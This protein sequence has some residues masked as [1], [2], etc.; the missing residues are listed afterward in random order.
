[1]AV[2]VRNGAGTGMYAGTDVGG[3]MPGAWHGGAGHRAQMVSN[4]IAARTTSAIQWPDR[5]VIATARRVRHE[6]QTGGTAGMREVQARR[7]SASAPGRQ[8]AICENLYDL[9]LAAVRWNRSSEGRELAPCLLHGSR[10]PE[11][12]GFHNNAAARDGFRDSCI[13][14]A[15]TTSVI[16]AIT[17]RASLRQAC[18]YLSLNF[19]TIQSCSPVR[20]PIATAVQPWSVQE[21]AYTFWNRATP[22]ALCLVGSGNP[23]CH[24]QDS[25]SRPIWPP[26]AKAYCDSVFFHRICIQ[27]RPM[28][29]PL[30]KISF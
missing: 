10:N 25:I 13:G 18:R 6:G 16:D 3:G 21:C 9:L 27:A 4:V 30:C 5:G 1:M 26:L 11:R 15:K 8:D 22:A 23:S 7:Q 19:Q 28:E 24:R 14:R 20:D 17:R 2:L 12:D 29:T